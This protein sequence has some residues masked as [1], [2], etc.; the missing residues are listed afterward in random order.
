MSDKHISN[1]EEYS[2]SEDEGDNRRDIHVA[3]EGNKGKRRKV[4]ATPVEQMVTNGVGNYE[5]SKSLSLSNDISSSKN[6]S[7]PVEEKE[8]PKSTV[9]VPKESSPQTVASSTAESST[10]PPPEQ[11]TSRKR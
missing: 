11:E 3:K 6:S 5:D 10:E 7:S 8:K 2:D 1:P 9:D 4:A